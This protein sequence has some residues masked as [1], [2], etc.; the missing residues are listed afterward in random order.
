VVSPAVEIVLA[1]HVEIP[2]FQAI[3]E[4]AATLFRTHPQTSGLDLPGTPASAFARG[5]VVWEHQSG[6]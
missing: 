2:R 5:E 6:R 4:R 3:E 1:S